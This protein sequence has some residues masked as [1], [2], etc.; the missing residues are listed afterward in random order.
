MSRET[1]GAFLDATAL[2]AVALGVFFGA[3]GAVVLLVFLGWRR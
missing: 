1:I 2:L 3:L